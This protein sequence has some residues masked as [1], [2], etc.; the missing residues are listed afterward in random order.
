M[1]TSGVDNR[2]ELQTAISLRK[3]VLEIIY[4]SKASHIGSSFSVI[5]ILSAV[6]RNIDISKIKDKRDDRDRVVLS[7]GH[8]AAALYVI[9]NHFG[10]LSD[11]QLATYYKNGSILSGHASH[12][13]PHVEHSTGALGHGLSVAVGIGIGL[14]SKDLDSRVYVIVG[15]GELNEG[16]NWEALLLAGHLKLD[17]L[18]VLVDLNGLGG[19]GDINC[20][21]SFDSLES[22]FESF[23]FTT[24]DVDGHDEEQIFQ[25]IQKL[26]K[27]K[28]PGAII[29]NTIKG[30]GVSFMENNNVWHYRPP[31]DEEYKKALLELSAREQA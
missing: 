6:Y 20:Y 4:Q 14:K 19:I 27:S 12:F 31:N 17:N 25:T 3:R 5:E 9:L 21:C 16:S 29:C 26:K 8:S 30:K 13:I 1:K 28:T 18:C 15:D 10:L 23:G 2:K 11:E 24:F 7:K 22:K